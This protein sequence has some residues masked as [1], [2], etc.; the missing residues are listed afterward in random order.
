MEQVTYFGPD[1]NRSMPSTFQI[2][3][4]LVF[5]S[6]LELLAIHDCKYGNITLTHV[7]ENGSVF[8][9]STNCPGSRTPEDFKE[10]LGGVTGKGS[11]EQSGSNFGSAGFPSMQ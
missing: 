3:A 2:L 7:A 11:K 10:A 5:S 4:F 9:I 6:T 1:M 8:T